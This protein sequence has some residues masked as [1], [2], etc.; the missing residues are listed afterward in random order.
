MSDWT[1]LR[2]PKCGASVTHPGHTTAPTRCAC[3]AKV[4]WN[5]AEACWTW[6]SYKADPTPRFNLARLKP[7]NGGPTAAGRTGKNRRPA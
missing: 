4:A 2:C 6:T 5:R 1:H 3:G 7:K